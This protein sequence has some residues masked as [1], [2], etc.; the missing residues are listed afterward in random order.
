[1]G[2]GVIVQAHEVIILRVRVARFSI[3]YN[4]QSNRPRQ[5]VSILSYWH[6]HGTPDLTSS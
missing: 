3:L 6:Y 5:Y 4:V 2:S 1:M